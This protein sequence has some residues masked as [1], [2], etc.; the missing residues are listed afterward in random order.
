MGFLKKKGKTLLAVSFCFFIL[1][2][3]IAVRYRMTYTSAA[4]R[5]IDKDGNDILAWV[6][7]NQLEMLWRKADVA[8]LVTPE[9][10]A[11]PGQLELARIRLKEAQTGIQDSEQRVR[12]VTG[13]RLEFFQKAHA[14]YRHS[15][16]ALIDIIDFLLAMQGKYSVEENEISFDSEIQAARFRVLIEQLSALQREK[17]ELDTFILNHNR[18][19]EKML[20]VR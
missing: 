9:K 6:E 12:D 2:Q 18:E 3:Q 16:S 14:Y 17:E 7:V 19:V 1:L 15:V 8:D 4:D 5:F 13:K 11:D 20:P 10:M